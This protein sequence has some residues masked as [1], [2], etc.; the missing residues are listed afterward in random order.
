LKLYRFS[1]DLQSSEPEVDSNSAD[2]AFVEGVISESEK[3]AG[4]ANT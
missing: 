3:E 1:I 2:V 4:F